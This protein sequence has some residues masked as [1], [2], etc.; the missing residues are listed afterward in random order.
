MG[1]EMG[2]KKLN[3]GKRIREIWWHTATLEGSGVE[4]SLHLK[5][6]ELF[7]NRLNTIGHSP[8]CEPVVSIWWTIRTWYLW[9][10][11]TIVLDPPWVQCRGPRGSWIDIIWSLINQVLSQHIIIL[12]HSSVNHSGGLLVITQSNRK[13]AYCSRNLHSILGLIT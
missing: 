10:L 6:L 4:N 1:T 5:Q 8:G 9:A 3:F 7:P 2:L 13:F 11:M 12:N